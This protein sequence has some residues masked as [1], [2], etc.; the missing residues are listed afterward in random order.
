MEKSKKR[1]KIFIGISITLGVIVI[2][3]FGVALLSKTPNILN[4]ENAI[5][6]KYSAWEQELTDRE[7]AVREKELQI[8]VNDIE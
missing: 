2:A 8:D 5:L 4:Y 3:L 1:S 7:N 6:D